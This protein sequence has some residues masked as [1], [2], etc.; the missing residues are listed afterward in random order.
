VNQL[1]GPSR[2][3]AGELAEFE[4]SK[5]IKILSI[6]LTTLLLVVGTSLAGPVKGPEVDGDPDSPMGAMHGKNVVL[7]DQAGT[8]LRSTKTQP[9]AN[10]ELWMR[11]LRAYFKLARHIS[12]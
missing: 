5:R 1:P 11:V 2:F 6:S 4:M 12:I 9:D 7:T 10:H 3:F 8:N